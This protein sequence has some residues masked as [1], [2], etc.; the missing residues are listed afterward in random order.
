MHDV[1]SRPAPRATCLARA[2]QLEVRVA[3]RP[4]EVDEALRL[5]HQV[6]T[7]EFDIDPGA[8]AGAEAAGPA[9]A[10][11]LDRDVFDAHCRHLVAIDGDTG[12]VVGTYRALLP[13]Q[14]RQLG[15][16][17]ADREFHLSWLNPIRHDLVEMGRACIAP[18]YRNGIV[19]M[20]LW[21]AMRELVACHGHQYV[22]GCCSVPL[23][24]GGVTA[25]RLYRQLAADHLAPPNQRVWPRNRLP[26]EAL[27]A[28]GVALGA[29]PEVEVPSLLKGYLRAGARILGEPHVD[30]QFGCAD[31]PIMLEVRAL[32]PRL[33]ARLSQRA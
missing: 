1:I 24:D 7:S 8:L 33:G 31:F 18:R 13:E 22:I 21:R 14:A 19:L 20:L 23:A 27:V 29:A 3:D 32:A 4:Q 12:R 25:A 9:G 30:P 28:R 2:G 6:F 5:R 10:P 17:Y 15:F 16:L 26:I 11:G